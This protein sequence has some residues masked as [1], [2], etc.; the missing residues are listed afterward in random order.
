MT[1]RDNFYDALHASP[2]DDMPPR[3]P[4]GMHYCIAC[5]I[6]D[7]DNS[8]ADGTSFQLVPSRFTVDGDSLCVPHAV[9]MA[10]DRGD[11]DAECDNKETTGNFPATEEETA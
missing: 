6:S 3:D 11:M 1:I 10:M 9:A 5:Y 4:E 7:R 8:R 2:R